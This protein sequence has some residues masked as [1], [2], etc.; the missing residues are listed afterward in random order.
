MLPA[1]LEHKSRFRL[2]K[3]FF[4]SLSLMLDPIFARKRLAIY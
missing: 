4:V 3:Q 2:S 1:D